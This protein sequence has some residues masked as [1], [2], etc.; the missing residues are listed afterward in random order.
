MKYL[1]RLSEWFLDK[2]FYSYMINLLEDEFDII[3]QAY[4]NDEKIAESKMKR[5]PQIGYTIEFLNKMELMPFKVES[6]SLS[7]NG[8]V[9]KCYG[10]RIK[11]KR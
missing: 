4:E 10:Y 8:C 1:R 3:I 9:C 2:F 6:I 7:H 11:E 5:L